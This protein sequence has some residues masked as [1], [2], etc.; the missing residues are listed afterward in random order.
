MIIEGENF[1]FEDTFETPITVADS[2]V[3]PKNK[4][5]DGNGEAKL[6]V[7]SRDKMERGKMSA[8]TPPYSPRPSN[9]RTAA[10]RTSVSAASRAIWD[11]SAVTMYPP[12]HTFINQKLINF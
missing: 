10:H 6:Y 12:H 7:G 5:G 3:M 11:V 9:I 1:K 2:W 8:T 4:L